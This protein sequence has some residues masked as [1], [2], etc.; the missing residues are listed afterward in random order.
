MAISHVIFVEHIINQVVESGIVVQAELDLLT[1]RI[2][3]QRSVIST[4]VNYN[5]KSKLAKDCVTELN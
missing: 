5:S 4:G 2:G 3:K 1:K